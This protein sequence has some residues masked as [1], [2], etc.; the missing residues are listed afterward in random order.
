MKLV[1]LVV[2]HCGPLR[3]SESAARPIKKFGTPVIDTIGPM[4]YSQV[5]TMLE[6]AFP[7]GALNYWKSNFL[8]SLTD[9]AMGTMIDCFARCPTPMGQ[10]LLEHVHG[11]VTR[12]GVTDTAFPHRAPGYNLLVL[13]ERLD[14]KDSDACIEWARDSYAALQPSLGRGRYVNYLGDD[15]PPA[16]VAA[17]HGPNHRRLQALEAKDDPENFFHMNQN[18]RP[19]SGLTHALECGDAARALRHAAVSPGD[20]VTARTRRRSW[21]GLQGRVHAQPFS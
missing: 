2:C 8:S 13:S 9:E 1:A 14:P 17:A 12:V 7:R 10:S 18:I 3:A 5:N 6:A 21:P 15:E 16:G 4:P 11:A 19:L 20:H